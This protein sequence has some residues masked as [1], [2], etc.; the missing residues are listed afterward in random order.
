M[1]KKELFSLFVCLLVL[2][3]CARGPSFKPVATK[4]NAAVVYVYGSAGLMTNYG[5]KLYISVN[6]KYQTTL[7]PGGYTYMVLAE[8]TH[9][10]K[11]NNREIVVDAK[12]G[13]VSYIE[14]DNSE[15]NVNFNLI[16]LGVPVP[17]GQMNVGLFGMG[18]SYISN[19]VKFMVKIQAE[20]DIKSKRL[21]PAINDGKLVPTT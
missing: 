20:Y 7:V 16:S 5:S 13:D 12:A 4:E 2:S 1:F 17:I 15:V 18:T 9:S 14:W 8:G 21:Q 6:N 3:G 10:L 11:F 19:D